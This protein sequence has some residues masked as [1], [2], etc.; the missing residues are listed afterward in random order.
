MM[1]DEEFLSPPADRAVNTIRMLA[2]DA[3]QKANSGHPGMP[4]G[5]A[6]YAFAL[7]MKYLRFNPAEPRW[8]DRDRFVLS[9]GHGSMLLYSLLHLFGFDMSIED[10][11]QFRQWESRT[12]GHPEYW[13]APGVETT[14]GPLG[15][16][17]GNGVGMALAAKML[18]ER[19]N[20]PG[21]KI[22]DHTIYGIVSDG[23]VMEGVSHEA[24]S[25]AGHLG[26]SN[27][28]YIY[29]DN[30]ITIE[31]DTALA[32]SED[33][34][35]RFQGYDWRVLKIDGHDRMAALS[36]LE[37]ARRERRRPT[38]IIARTHI[39]KGSPN[40]QDTA[41]AHGEPLGEE[42]VTATK[43]NLGWPLEPTFFVPEDVRELF[44]SRARELK[45]EYDAWARKFARYRKKF[46]DMAELW[47]A[48]FGKHVPG[49]I[50]ERLLASVGE[51][52]GATRDASGQ[53][54]QT[55]AELVPALCG[56][57]GDLAPSTKT[58]LK[59][60]ESVRKGHFGGRNFHFGVREH[61]MGSALNGMALHGGFIPYGA[62][63]LIF[64]DYMRP[65]IRLAA[66][67]GAQVIYVFTHDSIFLGEDGPTHQPVEHLPSLRAIP[68]LV[69]IRP[70]DAAETAV[71]WAVALRRSEGPTALVLTRQKVPNIDRS[72]CAG[73]GNL[74]LGAYV[75]SEAEKSPPDAIVI[76]SGSEVHVALEAQTLLRESGISARVVNMASMELFERQADEYRRSVLPAEVTARVAVEAA[77]PFGWDR[78]VGPKGIVLGVSRFGASAP[79]KVL[80]E[81]FGFTGPQ[82]AERIRGYLGS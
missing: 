61:C 77:A 42:E 67:M 71:A 35:R 10:I 53:V 73:A 6:D 60:Y 11:K 46:P 78:Y 79:Y 14:T 27:L 18:A 52:S 15:Q 19:F 68:N 72:K 45:S 44:L 74:K 50:E 82:V 51:F 57:A 1:K 70:A 37:K 3:V 63:F 5:A 65:T 21:F 64:S 47:D 75:A 38:L 66:M 7:W 81:K 49:D 30:H 39:A 20:R 4:M 22:L 26:L 56:G 55:A 69:V 76:A 54:L 16:G 59:K 48:T 9:A 40:K 23:D 58:L 43:N 12:P 24:A 8:P 17:F 41:A 2:V 34:G 28:I 31:G 32:F 13:C 80:A 33:V 29:D 36:A 62:T 25:L